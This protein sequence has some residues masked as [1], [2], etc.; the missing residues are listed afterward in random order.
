[1]KMKLFRIFLAA[2]L[3]L[4]AFPALC[5]PEMADALRAEGKIYVV[6]AIILVILIALILYLFVLDKKV[7]KL[8]SL[9]R[10]KQ[11]QTK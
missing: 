2:I 7:N 9:L 6:V 8:E 1:M 4:L 11:G 10:E 3:S 5:Q